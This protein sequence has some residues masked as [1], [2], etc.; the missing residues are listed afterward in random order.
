MGKCCS[1][2]CFAILTLL[3]IGLTLAVF[4]VALIAYVKFKF[5]N[6]TVFIVIIVCLCVSTLLLLF[7]IYASCCGKNC[8][9]TLL[10]ILY[11][12]YALALGAGGVLILIYQDELGNYLEKIANNGHLTP[13]EREIIEDFFDC[14]FTNTTDNADSSDNDCVEMF[15]DYIDK[16]GLI[17]AIALLVL[18]ALLMVGV[19]IACRLMWKKENEYEIGKNSNKL[20]NAVNQ[21][22]TY[23]W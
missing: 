20:E 17:V 1:S 22:L 3:T 2:T 4:I 7:G 8:S 14:N 11:I 16:Y 15:K 12:I 19:V 13:N 21:P 10:S 18:F 5:L 6:N 23:G 9:K